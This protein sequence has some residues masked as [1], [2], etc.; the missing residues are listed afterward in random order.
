M[1]LVLTIAFTLARNV[2]SDSSFRLVPCI[3]S[4]ATKIECADLIW[5]S[6]TPP[7]IASSTRI[8]FPLDPLTT[9]LQ[10]E[11]TDFL[12]VHL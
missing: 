2:Q 6:H 8:P 11:L 4:S 12:V 7:H 1:G 3:F 9:M 5:R 10:H